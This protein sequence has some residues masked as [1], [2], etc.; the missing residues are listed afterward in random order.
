MM[1]SLIIDLLFASLNQLVESLTGLERIL[2]T[3]IPLSFV[4]LY[5]YNF[6]FRSNEPLIVGTLLI[7]GLLPPYTV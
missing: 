3:P 2:T 4:Y 1:F 6:N 7:F 5:I